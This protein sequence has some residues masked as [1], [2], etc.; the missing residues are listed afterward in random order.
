[1]FDEYYYVKK[2]TENDCGDTLAYEEQGSRLKKQ[3]LMIKSVKSKSK[4]KSKK[5]NSKDV[6]KK[7][8][9]SNSRN[10]KSRSKINI[11]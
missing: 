9:S 5:L 3:P 7:M 1:M 10:S 8:T 2:D 4:S 6:G 11:S